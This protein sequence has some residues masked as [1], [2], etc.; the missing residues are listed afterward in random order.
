MKCLPSNKIKSNSRMIK[1]FWWF[2]WSR[3]WPLPSSF[4]SRPPW[5]SSLLFVFASRCRIWVAIFS[6][7]F[8]YLRDHT[9]HLRTTFKNIFY[10]C[11]CIQQRSSF[12]PF[13]ICQNLPEPNYYNLGD[14]CSGFLLEVGY[15]IVYR[16]TRL[17][18][19]ILRFSF[20][21]TPAEQFTFGHDPAE[22]YCHAEI[23][24]LFGKKKIGT[25]NGNLNI[26]GL[27]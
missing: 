18:T 9:R 19:I 14:I 7:I 1:K 27:Q 20:G 11:T 24:K 13:L 17:G 10:Q 16:L 26:I 12:K 25:R 21:V 5:L 15:F 4:S 8:R 22:K 6:S 23:H 3:Y 2:K